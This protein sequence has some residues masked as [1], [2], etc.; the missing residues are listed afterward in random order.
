MEYRHWNEDS[1]DVGLRR[2]T[3]WI[4]DW[5]K[6]VIMLLLYQM[7]LDSLLKSTWKLIYSAMHRINDFQA[8]DTSVPVYHDVWH[9]GK[10]ETAGDMLQLVDI[11][12]S[13]I[14]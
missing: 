8:N 12:D 13:W 11:K 5:T 10:S 14:S 2:S 9:Y 6:V 4:T 1:Y 3:R 7:G